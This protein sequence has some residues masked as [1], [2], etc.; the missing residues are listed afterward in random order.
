MLDS[1]KD[2]G[3]GS[4]SQS[5]VQPEMLPDKFE[6]GTLNTPGIAGLSEG[7]KFIKRVGIDNIRKHEEALIT[8]LCEELSKLS[9]IKIYG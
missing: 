4:E 3:T 2:G 5:T 9:Y 7:I 8:Y 6:I 1:F